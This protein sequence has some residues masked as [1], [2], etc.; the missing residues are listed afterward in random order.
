MG[1][2]MIR[3]FKKKQ[4]KKVEYFVREASPCHGIT[5]ER[6]VSDANTQGCKII[7]V[8]KSGER[9]DYTVILEREVL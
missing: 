6:I 3:L 2:G 5:L 4:P 9:Y 1:F 8:I 7:S